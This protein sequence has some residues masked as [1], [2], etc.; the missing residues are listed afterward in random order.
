MLSCSVS[1]LFDQL[2]CAESLHHFLRSR[3]SGTR[4]LR[5]SD[6]VLASR[7]CF[8][9]F[10]YS[11]TLLKYRWPYNNYIIKCLRFRNLR[12]KLTKEIRLSHWGLS[13]QRRPTFFAQINR[14]SGR[15]RKTFSCCSRY[16]REFSK[17]MI[18]RSIMKSLGRWSSQSSL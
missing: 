1:W 16:A 17:G 14:E 5:S 2:S 15:D 9:L 4:T 13:R 6:S 3:E 12:K 10:V 18:C 7:I 11:L 8:Y